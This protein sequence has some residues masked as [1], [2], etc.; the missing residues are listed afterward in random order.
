MNASPWL[1]LALFGTFA[2]SLNDEGP[3]ASAAGAGQGGQV[4]AAGTSNGGS[5]AGS[6][7][8]SGGSAGA[9]T[10][11]GNAGAAVV[12]GGAGS[13]AGSGGASGGSAG[14]AGAGGTA[15]KPVCPEGPFAKPAAGQATTVCQGFQYAHDYNEGPTWVASQGAFFFSNFVQGA[16]GGDVTGDIIKYTPGGNCEVFIKDVGTNGL[17]VSTKGNLLGATHK[18]R[19][20]T[21]FDIVT[22]QLTV[23]S[24][25]YMGK[26]LDSPNDLVQSSS[27]NIY[28]SNPTYELG[29]RPVGVGGAIFR[30][31]PQGTL[32]LLK[33][34][35]APNGVALSPK[36]DR[37]YV[38]NG[39]LWDLDANGVASN[40]RDFPL[41]ADGLAV[42]CAGNVYL[43]GGSVRDPAG[44]EIAKFAGGTNLAF[45][46]PDGKT[47]I[48]IG[49]GTSVK[50]IPMNVPGL[51]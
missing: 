48:V 37:L 45:G 34:S 20:I 6:T 9:S 23:L 19:S 18:T 33:Q 7:P 31:D 44:V 26:L 43:S 35:G 8:V 30:R 41:N 3:A 39:G 10:M 47:L 15:S 14:A 17:A 46:G 25:M 50:V 13:S 27:G 24:D 22:K 42:D 49:G 38:V 29:G 36:E 32:T 2:C 21:E 51:P 16:N 11:G 40:N 5:A 4:T 1:A 28:F 12:G